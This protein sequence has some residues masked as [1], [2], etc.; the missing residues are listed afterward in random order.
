M[1][2]APRYVPF[3][4]AGLALGVI[5]ALV[6]T[7]VPPDS[8]YDRSTLFGFFAVVF[9]V[10]GL[11]LGG[12]AALLVDWLGRRRSRLARVEPAEDV[13]GADTD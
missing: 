10:F 4:I 1:R 7:F 9:M 11:T 2:T 5:A 13:A 12:A 8:E 3:L 6:A